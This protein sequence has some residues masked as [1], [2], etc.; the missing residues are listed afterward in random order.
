MTQQS[1]AISLSGRAGP[2]SFRGDAPAGA[3]DVEHVH[4][5]APIL[6][7]R[8]AVDATL[9]DEAILSSLGSIMC[10]S[11]RRA[12]W[13]AAFDSPLGHFL[14]TRGTDLNTALNTILAALPAARF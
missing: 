1:L 2:P 10:H 13:R 8:L 3:I 7:E 12:R 5:L 14:A 11:E 6:R 9:T 4:E